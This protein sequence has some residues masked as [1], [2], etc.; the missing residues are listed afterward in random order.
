MRH[1]ASQLTLTSKVG[2]C[3]SASLLSLL[4]VHLSCVSINTSR[5]C[6][7]VKLTASFW[8]DIFTHKY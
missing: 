5:D 2:N 4:D 7:D 6:S 8:T 3:I 1:F